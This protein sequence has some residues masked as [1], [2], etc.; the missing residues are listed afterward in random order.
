LDWERLNHKQSFDA[1]VQSLNAQ[2]KQL[3]ELLE[4]ILDVED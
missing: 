1:N 4:N 3:R 2:N